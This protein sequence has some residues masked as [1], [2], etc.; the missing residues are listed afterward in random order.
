SLFGRARFEDA[1]C[2]ESVDLSFTRFTEPVSFDGI[3]FESGVT[4]DEARFESDASFAESAFEEGATFRGVE[5]QGGAHTVTDANFEAATFADSADFKLAEFRVADFS[6]AEFEGTALFERTVFEDDGTFRNAE[7]GASAVFSR[8]RFLEES[9]FSSC[10][11]GGEAHFDELRFEKD[12]TFA[13]AEF[14][15]DATFRSAEFEGSANMHNDDASFEAATFR[16]KADFDKASFLY[17][18]FTHTTFARDAAFTEAEFEHSVAFRPRPAES[19]TLVDLSDA[20]VRGGTLGQPEQGDAFYDCTHAE[21]REV[22]L[23]DE[24]CTH[25]LFNHFR[26]CNTDFHGFDFTAH[27]TY[28]ARNNWEIHTFAATEAADR[29]E[30]EREFTPARLENTYLKAKNCASDFGDRKAAAEFFIKEMVYRRRKNWRAAFT[31]E[32]AVSPVN[33]TKALG[34]W[35]GNKV[36]HQTCGYGERLWRVVYVSAVTVFIW[37]VLYTTTTQGTTGSSGLTTQGIGGLS[38]LFSPEGAVV[39]G[40]NMY[41]SMVTFTTLGY[42]DIQPVG[43]TARALAGLEAFLGALLVALVVFVLGRRVAW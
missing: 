31:R 5:F 26:F 30:T 15:G 39:L 40:K 21:V 42:G 3:A 16:G 36:L 34:K 37:G 10:R 32:E 4:A 43:S 22:T 28:L 13:D 17:A 20:V 19:E 25:G 18:N 9:D 23:D 27:K 24:H 6:G 41:F 11:F 35:I 7:F 29:S 14:G 1:V 8:S 12:S 38:N 33:R 2:T